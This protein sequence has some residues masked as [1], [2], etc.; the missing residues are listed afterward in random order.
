M[1]YSF[2]NAKKWGNLIS[3]HFRFYVFQMKTGGG[4]T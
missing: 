3:A 1:E 4:V 2:I